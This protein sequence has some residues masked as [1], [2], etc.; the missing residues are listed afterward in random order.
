MLPRK[1][2]LV[3]IKFAISIAILGWLYYQAETSG[4]IDSFLVA[5]KQWPWLFAALVTVFLT[6]MVSFTRWYLLVRAV[7][8]PLSWHDS[9]RFGFIG[10][11]MNFVAFGT[12][13]GDAIKAV[14]IYRQ[15][16]S[17]AAEAFAS[18]AADRALGLL[19][20]V[21][22]TS[23]AFLFFDFSDVIESHPD[24]WKYIQTVCYV[25]I[26][27]TIAGVTG[28]VVVFMVPAIQSRQF[29]ERARRWPLM[30][31]AIAKIVSIARAYRD[32]WL[33]LLIAF[34]LSLVI[35][36]LFAST[37]Y[38]IARGVAPNHP[39]F[40]QHFV[41][42]PISM[43]ANAVPLPGGIGGM[44][45]ALN[46]LYNAMTQA[47]DASDKQGF[48]VSVVFRLMLLSVAATGLPIYFI[49]RRRISSLQNDPL[50]EV[51]S[52]DVK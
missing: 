30:A 26:G 25:A 49:N 52:E 22:V 8:L 38:F 40:L 50:V 28:I 33:V 21:S 9:I 5:D 24:Q 11:T 34:G 35:N 17:R 13:G 3:F 23:F 44:E 16:K 43:V 12:L 39:T 32:R 10:Q 31:K 46:N 48:V 45:F 37:I 6:F 18:I 4:Q 36:L 42:A 2:I 27:A 47:E 29:V 51:E 19:A 7:G 15:V 14:L 41:I 1:A 20:M